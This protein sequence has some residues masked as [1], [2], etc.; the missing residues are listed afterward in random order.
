LIKDFGSNGN[1]KD[2]S[3]TSLT[4]GQKLF[5]RLSKYEQSIL[6]FAR[7]KEVGFTNN[8]AERERFAVVKLSKKFL[9]IFGQYKRQKHMCGLQVL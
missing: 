5:V 1:R 4:D 2:L 3:E 8:R 6:M 7:I 9:D